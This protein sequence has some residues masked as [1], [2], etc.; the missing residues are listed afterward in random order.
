MGGTEVLRVV[1]CLYLCWGFFFVERY[2]LLLVLESHIENLSKLSVVYNMAQELQLSGVKG[3]GAALAAPC[4]I[5]LYLSHQR[6]VDG[7]AML[8]PAISAPE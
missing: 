7:C 1:S 8:G 6:S 3:P 5:T 4:L 2:P